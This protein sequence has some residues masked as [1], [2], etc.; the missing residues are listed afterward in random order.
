MTKL[1]QLKAALATRTTEVAAQESEAAEVL[2]L[3]AK[4]AR[5]NDPMASKAR[6]ATSITKATTD[7]LTSLM[8]GCEEIVNSNPIYSARTRENRKWRPSR[9]QG[10]GTQVALL[11]G[12]LSGIMYSAADH[13][14]LM[15]DLVKL[16]E[17][18]IEAT[19]EAFGSPAYFSTNYN[20]IIEELPANVD[21][22][23]SNIEL[24]NDLLDI[25]IDTS[26]ITQRTF[27]VR[28]EVARLRAQ[29]DSLDA[30]NVEAIADKSLVI[31]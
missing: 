30:S 27:D 24:I 18:V 3:T 23:K 4:L 25:Q 5:L 10:L 9:V 22:I 29:R 21:A 1:E 11:T 6:V 8:L 14:M 28:F 15:L 7:K 19:L 2:R 13:K 17:D 20:T 31:E 16:P 12:L 26:R